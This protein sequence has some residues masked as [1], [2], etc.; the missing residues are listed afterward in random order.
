MSDRLRKRSRPAGVHVAGRGKQR[1]GRIAQAGRHRR[2]GGHE[3]QRPAAPRASST[4]SSATRPALDPE[5]VPRWPAR[6]ASSASPT[7]AAN[8]SPAH[9]TTV[10]Q[11]RANCCERSAGRRR[12]PAAA[13]SASV[14]PMSATAWEKRGGPHLWQRLQARGRPAARRP[15]RTARASAPARGTGRTPARIARAGSRAGCT[16]P[17]PAAARR[18]RGRARSAGPAAL[19]RVPLATRANDAQCRPAAGR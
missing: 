14:S 1:G 8:A 16:R 2:S 7:A 12:R 17:A 11:R 10:G 4:K 15:A 19:L 6:P 3:G 13:T 5:R 18:R 9:A